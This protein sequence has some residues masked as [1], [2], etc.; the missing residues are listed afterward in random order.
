MYDIQQSILDIFI[1][2]LLSMKNKSKLE[3]RR[4][5]QYTLLDIV[6]FEDTTCPGE[7][8]ILFIGQQCILGKNTA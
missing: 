8:L 7:I 6:D 4:L 3:S 1:D 2:I 5:S